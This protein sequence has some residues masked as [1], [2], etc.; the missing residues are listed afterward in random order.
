LRAT[1]STTLLLKSVVAQMLV[2]QMSVAL[3][4]DA[5]RALLFLNV[6]KINLE[7][8][9]L[10]LEKA[11]VQTFSVLPYAAQVQVIHVLFTI[12]ETSVSVLNLLASNV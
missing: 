10:E 2:V 3:M 1:K 11:V 6:L 8:E 12:R 4:R 9:I 7:K 5:G